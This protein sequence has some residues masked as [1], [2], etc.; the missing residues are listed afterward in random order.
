MHQ[1]RQIELEGVRLCLFWSRQRV[2]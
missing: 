2:W 1:D